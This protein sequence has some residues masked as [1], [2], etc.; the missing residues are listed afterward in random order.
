MGPTPRGPSLK[1]TL[2][3][4]YKGYSKGYFKETLYIGLFKGIL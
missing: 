3:P 2:K 4:A 1:T